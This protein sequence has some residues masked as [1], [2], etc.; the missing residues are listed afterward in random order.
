[1][2][3]FLAA[4]LGAESGRVIAGILDSSG[5]RLEQLSRFPNLPRQV[6]G[7]L[8]WDLEA[9]WSGI[10]EGLAKGMKTFG[11]AVTSI[12]VDT[13]GVDFVLLD[14]NLEMVCP[15]G[16]YRDPRTQGV[17]DRLDATLSPQDWFARTGIRPLP[18]NSCYQ[19]AAIKAQHPEWLERAHHILTI[20]DWFHWRLSGV[21]SNEWTNASTTQLAKSGGKGWD[22]ETI[23]RLGLPTRLF[24]KNPTPTST[25]LGDLR[26]DLAKTLGAPSGVKIILPA[27][28]DTGSACAAIPG[29]VSDS[30]FI[31]CGTWSLMGMVVPTAITSETARLG[32]LSNELAWDGQT[33]LLENIMGLWVIQNHRR[34]I[35][36]LGREYDY[37]TLERLAD[38]AGPQVPLDIDDPRFFAPHEA[39]ND[40]LA[41]IESWF[42][43]K[44]L[45][46]SVSDGAISR[47]ITDG[48]AQA[49]ARCRERLEKASARPIRRIHLLGGGSKN[50]L[51]AKLTKE[52]TGVE[53]VCGPAEATA[54]G[55]ILLQA[56]GAKVITP[57]QMAALAASAR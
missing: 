29:D 4:D 51:L 21:L 6:D 46:V 20:P 37:P 32:N 2:H 44:K 19:L 1:M 50:L 34:A 26:P 14:K 54:V 9:L 10:C 53:V 49:Y 39:A 52:A 36:A 35:A 23:T 41:R 8:A 24:A 13:W 18:F 28:H 5:L 45:P 57:N 55:N 38:E 56:V 33:R 27:C 12:G 31:S 22:T 40:Y 25:V 42:H 17:K 15:A 11:S 16:C 43:D 48:L 3:V 47:S 7:L 30:A